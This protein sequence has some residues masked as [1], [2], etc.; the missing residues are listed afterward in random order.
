MYR[1]FLMVLALAACSIDRS[2]QADQGPAGNW[3]VKV[4]V[5][6]VGEGIRTVILK[7]NK[8][9]DQKYDI[10]MS[11]MSGKLDD[12]DESEVK[13]ENELF[14]VMGSYE[15]TLQFDGDMVKGTVVSPA[16]KQNVTGH[17]QESA[18]ILG[19]EV[20]PLRRSWRGIIEKRDGTLMMVS[21]RGFDTFFT[22]VEEFETDLT[23]NE[24]LEVVVTGWW[25]KTKIKIQKL[26]L[27][28]QQ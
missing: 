13:S 15:Y 14:I 9:G 1:Y 11:K 19:D 21:R 4:K 22:N 8:T 17:R 6:H 12:V 24:G 28:E 16:G 26:E 2:V 25:I 7:I 18:R 5:G 20:D 3:S 27:Y 10:K 23:K